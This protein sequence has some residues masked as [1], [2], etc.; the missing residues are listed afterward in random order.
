MTTR[1]AI[2][3]TPKLGPDFARLWSASAVTNLCDGITLAAGPL[4]VASLTDDPAAIGGAAFV[5]Q[6]PWLLFAILSGVL[7]DRVDRR[8]LI[9]TADL[10]RAVVIGGPAVAVATGNVTIP[11]VYTAFFLIGT[12]ETV[13][14]SASSALV[15]AI[16]A[17][18][19]L[20]KANG[21]LTAVVV[22]GN[23]F[24]APPVGAALFVLAAAVPFGVNAGLFVI[25]ALL[26]ATVRYRPRPRTEHARVAIRTEIVEGLRWAWSHR[27]LRAMAVSLC[28]MNIALMGA[29]AVLVLYAREQLGLP[30]AAFGLLIASTAVGG[31][32]GSVVAA[33]LQRRFG[34]SLLVRIGLLIET[35]THFGLALTHSPWVAGTIFAVFGLHGA[36]FGVVL[37]SARQRAV[38]DR[39]R[40]RVGGVYA[41]LISGG[42]AIGSLVGGFVARGFGVTA[43]FWA[44]G[45]AMVV[46]TACVWR[47]FRP[48]MFAEPTPA[49]HD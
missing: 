35:A 36:V 39:L 31:L 19:A 42:A 40:G 28:L 15:P 30:D 8:R 9:I 25:G 17:P 24:V 46:L 7:V 21:R 4:L 41:L 27:L 11:L 38:P 22:V 14:D 33:P 34:D 20:P 12:A 26:M 1:T 23:M 49:V 16:V 44:A 3:A 13:A 43:P 45:V 18:D 10:L 2:P 6:L 29:L 32:L 47:T 5:Q 37:V 48:S